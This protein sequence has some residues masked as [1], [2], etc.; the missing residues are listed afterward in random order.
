MNIIYREMKIHENIYR[1]QTIPNR[2]IPSF[3]LSP[4]NDSQHEHRGKDRLCQNKFQHNARSFSAKRT[5]LK[6]LVI[7][8]ARL[9]YQQI[10]ER[11]SKYLIEIFLGSWRS[12]IEELQ[13]KQILSRSIVSESKVAAPK[14]SFIRVLQKKRE[15]CNGSPLQNNP[16]WM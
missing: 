2:S 1:W 5:V 4:D 14:Q 11:L 3:S 15:Q 10:L 7:S 13:H 12:E 8:I 9:D 6:Q 16:Q